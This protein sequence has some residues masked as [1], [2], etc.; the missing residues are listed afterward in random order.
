MKATA[1]HPAQPCVSGR[2]W[3]AD[4]RF[5]ARRYKNHP[6]AIGADLRNELQFGATWGG[7]DPALDL[8]AAAERGGNAILAEN[9][10][11]LIFARLPVKRLSFA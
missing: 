10:N 3:R 11:L 6:A 5:L 8:H 9:P 4:W 2:S 1:T 7:Q